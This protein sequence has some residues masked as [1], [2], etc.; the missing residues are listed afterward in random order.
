M[1]SASSKTAIIAA[2][3]RAEGEGLE[4]VGL[5]FAGNRESGELIHAM[6]ACE[7][8]V[9]IIH[10]PSSDERV[11]STNL[12]GGSRP[13]WGRASDLAPHDTIEFPGSTTHP[14]CF[15]VPQPSSCRGGVSEDQ[16]HQDFR[17]FR[18]R[19]AERTVF[20]W[21]VCRCSTPAFSKP[22]IPTG[23]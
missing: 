18:R 6:C 10:G 11:F 17:P 13:G 8:D 19:R 23:T 15:R 7:V 12:P 20:T 21:I 16:Q 1:S 3:L 4:V 5:T 22:R 2:Y 9:A 14:W